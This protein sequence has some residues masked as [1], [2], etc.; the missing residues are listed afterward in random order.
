MGFVECRLKM[1]E[2]VCAAKSIFKVNR[3]PEMENILTEDQVID[4]CDFIDDHIHIEF[5]EAT[6]R[7]NSQCDHSLKWTKKWIASVGLNEN[8]VLEFCQSWGGSHCDC[9]VILNVPNSYGL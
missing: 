2:K 3:M 4:M 5:D 9:E 7:L 8:E 1:F 6:N